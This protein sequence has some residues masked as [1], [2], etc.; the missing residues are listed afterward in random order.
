MNI[1]LAMRQEVFFYYIAY[2]IKTN[3]Q[4]MKTVF[5]TPVICCLWSGSVDELVDWGRFPSCLVWFHTREMSGKTESVKKKPRESR[6]PLHLLVTS[7][8]VLA[9]V[10]RKVYFLSGHIIGNVPAESASLHHSGHH[11]GPYIKQR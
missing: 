7:H 5:S 9:G 1:N 2:K 3:R 11:F 6:R 4:L 8:V 10:E